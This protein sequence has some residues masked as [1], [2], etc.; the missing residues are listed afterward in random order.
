LN[1]TS[2]RVLLVDDDDIVRAALTS[3]LRRSG[4]DVACAASGEEALR[5]LGAAR[6][7]VLL[8][9]W[10]MPN[11]DGL[12]LC[13]KVRLEHKKEDV[14]LI[15]L[16]MRTQEHEQLLGLAAGADDYIS[17]A[18]PAAAILERLDAV[19]RKQTADGQEAIADAAPFSSSGDLS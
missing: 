16:T 2:W 9:D 7:R 18:A 10:E 14:Y 3:L 8:T 6:Y 11:M 17:K 5:M 1:P 4:Y 13:R 12:E 19:R 15:M